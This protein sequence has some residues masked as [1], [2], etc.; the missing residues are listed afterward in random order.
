MV[1]KYTNPGDTV[2]D[3]F[4]GSGTTV[5]AA[6]DLRRRAV[7]IELD[8]IQYEAMTSMVN[9]RSRQPALF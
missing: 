4:D 5:M 8:P 6:L 3:P 1:Q 9:T 2:L 7:G